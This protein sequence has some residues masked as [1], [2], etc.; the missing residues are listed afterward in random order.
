MKRQPWTQEEDSLLLSL[1]K[2]HSIE[3]KWEKVSYHMKEAGYSKSVKQIKARWN[4]NLRPSLNKQKWTSEDSA[5]LLDTFQQKG[6]RWTLIKKEFNGRTDNFVKNQFFSIIRR[7]LRAAIKEI[8][9][10]SEN[11]GTDTVNRIKPR[12]LINFMAETLDVGVESGVTKEVKTIDFVKRFA[13]GDKKL[14]ELF[15]LENQKSLIGTFFKRL[16]DLNLQYKKQKEDERMY[17]LLSHQRQQNNNLKTKRGNRNLSGLRMKLKRISELAE[18]VSM[19]K[20]NSK[21]AKEK[22]NGILDNLEKT[23]QEVRKQSYFV[24]QEQFKLEPIIPPSKT[25]L[26]PVMTQQSESQRRIGLLNK[27]EEIK[28]FLIIDADEQGESSFPNFEAYNNSFDFDDSINRGNPGSF[29]GEDSLKINRNNQK[30]NSL[31]WEDIQSDEEEEE[32]FGDY[33]R[34]KK[35]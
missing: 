26:D 31:I 20:L 7:S 13:F 24:E 18:T 14:D 35:G 29:L 16:N 10:T 4:N 2:E 23:I 8:E 17:K 34:V 15:N 27:R 1:M 25:K 28:S 12:V 30:E 22:L 11:G 9:I 6:N 3:P 32:D 5:L 19:L 21:N 33:K